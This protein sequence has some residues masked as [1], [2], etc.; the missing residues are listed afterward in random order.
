[1]TPALRRLLDVTIAVLAD[2]GQADAA[3]VLRHRTA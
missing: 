3:H 1:M 2:A